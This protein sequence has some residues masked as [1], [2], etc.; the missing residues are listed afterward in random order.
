[1]ERA[2]AAAEKKPSKWLYWSVITIEVDNLCTNYQ[3]YLLIKLKNQYFTEINSR[4]I[5]QSGDFEIG[6]K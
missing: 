6:D 3:I 2:V 5:E 4:L 1:M